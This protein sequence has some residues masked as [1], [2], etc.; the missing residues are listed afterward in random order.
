MQTNNPSRMDHDTNWLGK[1]SDLQ[2]LAFH[3]HLLDWLC[4]QSK[5]HKI[6]MIMSILYKETST[7]DM[8][9]SSTNKKLKEFVY[10]NSRCYG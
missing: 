5:Q 10:I 7:C 8:I 1:S 9:R 3:S 6:E 4:N 2:L